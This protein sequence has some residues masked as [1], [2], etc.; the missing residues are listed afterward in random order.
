MSCAF[1][2]DDQIAMIVELPRRIS[3]GTPVTDG[4]N[5]V[6]IWHVR[7]R[8]AL[9]SLLNAVRIPGA[10]KSSKIKDKTTADDIHIS[11]GRLFTTVAVNGR[12]HYFDRITGKYAGS[13]SVVHYPTR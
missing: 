6:Q 11:V 12:H 13:G 4:A 5:R 10:I 2:S 7:L 3:L 9:G 8:L 1:E